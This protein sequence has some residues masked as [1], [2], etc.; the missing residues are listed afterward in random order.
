MGDITLVWKMR[1]R[2]VKGREEGRDRGEETTECSD[3]GLYV[4]FCICNDTRIYVKHLLYINTCM[5]TNY[6]QHKPEFPHEQHTLSSSKPYDSHSY[7]STKQIQTLVSLWLSSTD[8]S[9]L[10]SHHKTVPMNPHWTIVNAPL[11]SLIS[12]TCFMPPDRSAATP[13]DRQQEEETQHLSWLER[14]REQ[15]STASRLL[16]GLTIPAQWLGQTV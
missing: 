6:S 2:R 7:S 14:S 10:I 12:K 15:S 13:A 3:S 1:H 9:H 5:I 16:R 11:C 8:C 4:P